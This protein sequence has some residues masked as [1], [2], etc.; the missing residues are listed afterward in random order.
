[1]FERIKPVTSA[2]VIKQL[3][4]P[5]NG[6]T[7]VELVVVIIILGILALTV[8]PR[9]VGGSDFEPY[10]YRTKLVAD[11]RLVQQRAMQQTSSDVVSESNV[12][13]CHKF[14]LYSTRYG[15]PSKSNC[16]AINQLP[17]GWLPD[18][19]GVIVDADHNVTFSLGF[20][21]PA[22]ITFDPLGRPQ[23][24]CIGGCTIIISSDAETLGVKIES[25]G[26]IHA[27]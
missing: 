25:E 3:T 20:I 27:I 26:Y 14:I 15:V 9:F 22:I 4:L 23:G 12:E 18:Q 8:V 21:T 16:A 6:F 5:A 13:F 11:L 2:K 17:N 24:S 19:A 1:M 7:I 10:A